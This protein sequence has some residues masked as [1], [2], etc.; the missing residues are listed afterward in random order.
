MCF[1]FTMNSNVDLV[2]Y[3][4]PSLALCI[5]NQAND[6][7]HLNHEKCS[8]LVMLPA[9]IYLQLIYNFTL[10]CTINFKCWL[11]YNCLFIC[12]IW[13]STNI[14]RLHT[15]RHITKE[16]PIQGKW[17]HLKIGCSNHIVTFY[18]FE[19]SFLCFCLFS[20]WSYLMKIRDF[21]LIKQCN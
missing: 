18:I 13:S 12:S 17:C 11:K 2:T 20:C 19:N 8:K 3:W 4:W 21:L 7:V 16:N 1:N 6:L 15:A 9:C 10:P 14:Y 5:M